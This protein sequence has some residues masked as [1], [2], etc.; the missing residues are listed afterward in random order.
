MGET[1]LTA[2]EAA[3]GKQVWANRNLSGSVIAARSGRL[4]VWDGH[5]ATTVDPARG[6]IVESVQLDGVTMIRTDQF[7]DGNLYLASTAG[8]VTRL[9]PRK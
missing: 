7:E 5:T 9:T 8:V 3:T 6:G 2:Y 1:G 4:L